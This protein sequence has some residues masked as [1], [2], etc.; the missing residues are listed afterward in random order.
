MPRP[1][2]D[3]QQELDAYQLYVDSGRTLSARALVEAS[4]RAVRV[5]G[6]SA[7]TYR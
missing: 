3:P 2:I 5:S 7:A 6:G 4:G 1:R